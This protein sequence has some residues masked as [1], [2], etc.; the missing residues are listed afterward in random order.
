LGGTLQERRLVKQA[1]CLLGVEMQSVGRA[2]AVHL[3][4]KTDE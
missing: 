2:I 4:L 1:G 3:H